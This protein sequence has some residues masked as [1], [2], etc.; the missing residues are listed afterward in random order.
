VLGV[1]QIVLRHHAVAGTHR[2][3]R[4][5]RVFLGD[6]LRGAA[7]LHIRTIA[8]IGAGE[9]IG[10]AAIVVVIVVI[11]IVAAAHAPILLLWPHP[12]LFR[13]KLLS[14]TGSQIRSRIWAVPPSVSRASRDMSSNSSFVC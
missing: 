12:I 6:L 13:L 14:P 7:D 3:T 2:V 9:R 4:Q 10:A 5:C 1:L 11:I 8:L